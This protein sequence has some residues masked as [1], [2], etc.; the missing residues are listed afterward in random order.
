MPV[1][2]EARSDRFGEALLQTCIVP[3][4]SHLFHSQS[5]SHRHHS[6][7]ARQREPGIQAAQCRMHVSKVAGFRVRRKPRRPGMTVC[8]K[9]AL[10]HPV[11]FSLH[12]L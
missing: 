3:A 10:I 4:V 12:P 6:G 8:A 7:G 11:H 1:S 5:A 2:D 9:T